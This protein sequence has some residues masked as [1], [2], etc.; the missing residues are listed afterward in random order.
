[1][2]IK[3]HLI[4]CEG[5]S[6]WGYLQRLQAFLDGQEVPP[7]AFEAPL[8]FIGP[9]HAIAKNG[10]FGKIKRTYNQT[11]KD[12]KT[13]SI[14]VWADFDLYRRNDNQSGDL[15]AAKTAGIPDFLFSFHNFEDFFALH[16]DGT[17]LAEWLRFGGLAGL[18][19]FT[20][21]LHSSGYLPEIERIFPGYAKRG[22]PADFVSWES[23]RNLK[24]NL[25]HQPLASIPHNLQNVRGFAEFLIREIEAAYPFVLDSIPAASAPNSPPP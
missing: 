12:N 22:L 15:Y 8:R 16:H 13:A 18:N 7:G 11:R 10:A 6:E 23:L 24:A 5:E 20:N 2:T 25:S 1:M 4:V 19:H 9:T 14:Q 3:R 21:P 17:A